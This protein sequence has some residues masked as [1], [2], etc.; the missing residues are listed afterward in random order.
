M[1]Q[2]IVIP[3]TP[4]TQFKGYHARSQR[5][6]KVVAHRRFGKT[7]GCLNDLVKLALENPR[8]F[9]P[10]RYAYVAPTYGQAKDTAWQYLKHYTSR[11]PNVKV[12]ESELSVTLPNGARI[13]LYGADNYDAL[14]GGYND[15]V[16]IDEPADID[17]RAWPEVIRPTLSDYKGWATFI[18]TPKGRNWFYKVGRLESGELDPEWLH[19]TLKAS[20]TGVLPSEELESARKLLTPEQYEQEYECSFEAAIVGA[21]YGRLMA[22]ADKDKRI[23]GVPYDPAVPVWTAW[24]LGV[25]DSTAIWFCQLVG[26]EIHVID[27]YEMTGVGLDHYASVIRSK[28]YGYASHIV[29]HD[30]QARELGTGKTRI[31]M[32]ASLGL[33]TEVAASHSVEDGIN[34]V[35]LA[36][37]RCWF[38]ANKCSRGIEA[39]K[40]YRAEYDD[41]L[42]TLRP[43]PIHDWASHGADAFRYFAMMIDRM[44]ETKHAKAKPVS[45]P[46]MSGG[47]MAA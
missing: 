42:Q 2:T 14:R 27:Y 26:R 13:R 25:R 33:K 12:M 3:Y 19:V 24:D 29:P 30:A 39:L 45:I 18:G 41:R 16:V 15:G 38:D 40:L 6:T 4:R 23:V 21:Y 28:P 47:W 11:L 7:V 43:R 8:A 34:A 35:R 5:W 1:D 46:R 22:D 10:P 36:L 37:P 9:P 44:I 31:E 20:E 17:P 32:L